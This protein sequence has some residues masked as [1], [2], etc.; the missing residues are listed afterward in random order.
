MYLD[1]SIDSPAQLWKL[2][3]F[4]ILQ[5]GTYNIINAIQSRV[6]DIS[7]GPKEVIGSPLNYEPYGSENQQVIG[8]SRQRTSSLT[9]PLQ[10][11]LCFLK[12]TSHC[13]M[14]AVA[15]RL[16]CGTESEIFY[17]VRTCER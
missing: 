15:P 14:Q 17:K 6:L 16:Y 13:T 12:G 5:C 9:D 4:G 10:W 8:I 3:Y 11:E 1:C 7:I 2:D